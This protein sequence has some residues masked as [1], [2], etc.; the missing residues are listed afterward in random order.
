MNKQ[1]LIKYISVIILGVLIFSLQSCSTEGCTDPSSK[2]YNEEANKDDGSC[3]YEGRIDM[4]FDADTHN[5]LLQNDITSIT[6]TISEGFFAD[7]TNSWQTTCLWC[8]AV[9]ENYQPCVY[10]ASSFL[11]YLGS[12][13]VKTIPYKIY[14]GKDNILW[15]GSVNCEANI[16]TSIK[17]TCPEK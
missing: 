15:E 6:F 5:W 14:D 4:W 10:D 3:E 17:L 12:D 1:N 7:G 2:N 13:N 8:L 11:I 16:C 9:D